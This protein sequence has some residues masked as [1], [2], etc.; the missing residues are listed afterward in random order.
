MIGEIA[1][2]HGLRGDVRVIPLTDDLDR[3]ERVR[4]CV[5]WDAAH[6]ERQPRRVQHARR[7]GDHVVLK[8]E[9]CESPVAAGA[10]APP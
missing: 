7:H 10:P 2:A 5:V 9:G 4:A 8:L 3:F 6:D 1:R